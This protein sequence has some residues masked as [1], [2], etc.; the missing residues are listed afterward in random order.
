MEYSNQRVD[1]K[2]ELNQRLNTLKGV[3]TENIEKLLQKEDK[4]ALLVHRS[5]NVD[6]FATGIKNS[7]AVLSLRRRGPPRPAEGGSRWG[8]SPWWC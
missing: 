3:L 7:V 8:S 4:V 5:N 2:A 6:E 1:R